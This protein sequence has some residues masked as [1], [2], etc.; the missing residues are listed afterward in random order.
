MILVLI[1]EANAMN[2]QTDYLDQADEEILSS[3]V[4]DDALE[5]A[6]G[7]GVR[8]DSGWTFGGP[9]HSSPGC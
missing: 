6:A 2:E 1:K 7:P 8:L 3:T 9:C 4:S 5:A